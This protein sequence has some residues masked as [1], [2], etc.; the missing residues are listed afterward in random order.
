LSA[1]TWSR[2]EASSAIAITGPKQALGAH[3]A[4]DARPALTRSTSNACIKDAAS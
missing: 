2:A 1:I 4:F 3:I